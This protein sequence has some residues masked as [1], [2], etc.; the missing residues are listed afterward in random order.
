MV[1]KLIILGSV[2]RQ[3]AQNQSSQDPET[4]DTSCAPAQ[5]P[6]HCPEETAHPEEQGGGLRVRQAA[7]QEDEGNILFSRWLHCHQLF[8]Y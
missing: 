8:L 2:K 6:P 7:G 1:A 3:E 4:G 5:A